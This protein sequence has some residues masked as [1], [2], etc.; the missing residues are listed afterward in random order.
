MLNQTISMRTVC[1]LTSCRVQAHLRSVSMYTCLH[2][3]TGWPL[4]KVFTAH[5]ESAVRCFT[6]GMLSLTVRG[7]RLPRPSDVTPSHI[8]HWRGGLTDVASVGLLLLGAWSWENLWRPDPSG[9][10]TA[11]LKRAIPQYETLIEARLN[12]GNAAPDARVCNDLTSQFSEFKSPERH[13]FCTGIAAT[14]SEVVAEVIA[15]ES[16]GFELPPLTS[17]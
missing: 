6:W 5:R 10:T 1:G 2:D 12:R 14:V 9:A 7:S 3:E 16:G 17:V 13:A 8:R 11:V 4:S 15:T